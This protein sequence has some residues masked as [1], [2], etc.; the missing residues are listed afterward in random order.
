MLCVKS[1][2]LN[3]VPA[4]K[5]YSRLPARRLG[6]RALVIGKPDEGPAR[7]ALQALDGAGL[8]PKTHRQPRMPHDA[9]CARAGLWLLFDFF[10]ESHELCQNIATPSGSYWHAILHRMD[11][12]RAT[13][14]TGS[15]AW[16]I[17]R[18]FNELLLDAREIAA[19][20]AE[21]RLQRILQG[22]AFDATLFTSLCCSKPAPDVGTDPAENSGA[23]MRAAF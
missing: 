20:C 13:R 10:H 4:S 5:S 15:G 3:T 1:L 12:T 21:P 8:A 9:D 19:N 16:A 14:T 2:S 23:R 7:A 11:Q 17:I 18:V 6:P 22:A